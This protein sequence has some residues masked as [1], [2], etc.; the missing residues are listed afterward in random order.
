MNKFLDRL[1]LYRFPLF[2]LVLCILAYGLLIPWLGFYWDDVPLA[3]FSRQLSPQSF[4]GYEP[5]R[6][7]SGWL[8]FFSFLLLR[9]SPLAWQIYGLVWRWLSAVAFWW[10]L[11]LLW[12]RAGRGLEVIALLFA[13]Y[14]GFSQQPISLTYSLYFL[15]YTLFLISLGLMLVALQAQGRRALLLTAAAVVAS[16]AVMFSTEYFYGLELL[17]PLLIWMAVRQ[18]GTPSHRRLGQIL[19]VWMPYLLAAAVAFVQRYLQSLQMAYEATLVTRLF[20]QP[21]ETLQALVITMLGDFFE[22]G[23][24]AWGQIISVMSGLVAGSRVAIVYVALLI[25]T[26]LLVMAFWWRGDK[27]ELKRKDTWPREA[28]GLGT[29]AL[30]LSGLSFWIAD[31]PMR[32]SFPW[33]R[34][35]LPMM[36]GVAL[37]L[38]GTIHLFKVPHWPK[39]ILLSLLLALSVGYHFLNANVYRL[40]WEN[41]Q[42][43][44]R[45]L[46]WRVPALEPQT[47]L[48][49]VQ[50]RSLPHYSDN[51]LTAP[52]NWIYNRQDDFSI[53]PYYFGY[54]DLR[55]GEGLNTGGDL[56]IDKEYRYWQFQGNGSDVLMLH[57][58]PPACLHILNPLTDAHFP[59]LPAMLAEQFDRSNLQRITPEKSTTS[60]H[61]FPADP[62]ES[63]CYY[64]EMADLSRQLGDWEQIAVLGDQAS[65]LTDLAAPTELMPFIEGYAHVGEWKKAL[66]LS[67]EAFGISPNVG[68]MLCDLWAR[69]DA[70]SEL[71]QMHEDAIVQAD[72]LFRCSLN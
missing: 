57:Y 49:T 51:S 32:L 21:L 33:D 7:A 71:S 10:L 37:I 59:R 65:A 44:T 15:Y 27:S 5:Y 56:P 1:G 28:I 53:L 63:W 66:D 26:L 61:L 67:Q 25:G 64:F 43:F 50:L 48:L 54:I 29:L 60:P 12:P 8:Y 3:W 22:A 16:L 35:T 47:A 11:R 58:E 23:L 39:T 62:E 4:I 13:L 18:R 42:N 40:E 9:E 24:A 6:P 46:Q 14:P 72:Q 38:G 69:V 36:F 2:A 20:L 34:F 30:M 68:A 55:A 45:Q 31:L 17:R 19:Q 52:I 70:S 41:L